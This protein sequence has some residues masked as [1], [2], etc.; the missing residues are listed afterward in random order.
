MKKLVLLFVM[1]LTLSL[2]ASAQVYQATVDE[3]FSPAGYPSFAPVTFKESW[4]YTSTGL[5]PGT[6]AYGFFIGTTETNNP[7]GL[8]PF[9]CDGFGCFA[10]GGDSIQ[11]SQVNAGY[12][13]TTFTPGTY[14]VNFTALICLDHGCGPFEGGYIQPTSGDLVIKQ[15]E[16]PAETPEPSTSL[17]LGAGV[18]LWGLIELL[19]RR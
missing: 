18:L 17:M 19:R 11:I 6:L 15:I 10:P 4:E 14:N 3:T 2:G 5:I 9:T 8:G 13:P 1:V 12:P 16:P 7:Y